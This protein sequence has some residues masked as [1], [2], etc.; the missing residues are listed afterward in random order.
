MNLIENIQKTQKIIS[1]F[2]RNSYKIVLAHGTFDLL[3][4]GHIKYLKFAKKFGEKLIVSITADKYVK[5][6]VADH[7]LKNF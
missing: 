1:Q 5:K 6:G 7:I 2:K 4:V 3:H